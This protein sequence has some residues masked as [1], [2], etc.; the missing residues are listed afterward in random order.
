[1]HQCSSAHARA[2]VRSE[3]WDTARADGPEL[4]DQHELTSRDVKRLVHLAF[5]GGD[6][7]GDDAY[8]RA[9]DGTAPARV[10][11]AVMLGQ[12]LR[13]AT[14]SPRGM[15]H[16]MVGRMVRSTQGDTQAAAAFW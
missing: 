6:V 10:K 7:E 1:M 14:A 11:Q 8:Q 4:A 9:L 2:V 13:S 5:H 15:P 16:R 3:R 12:G